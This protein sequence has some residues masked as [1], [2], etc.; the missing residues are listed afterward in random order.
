LRRFGYAGTGLLLLVQLAGCSGTYHDDPPEQLALDLVQLTG[1]DRET[2]DINP[3]EVVAIRTPR[4]HHRVL[5]PEANCAVLTTDGKFI[6]V[7]ETCQQVRQLLG[8]A[9]DHK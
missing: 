2:I 8:Q 9:R 7:L 5:P 1:L 6:S 3:G 4:V